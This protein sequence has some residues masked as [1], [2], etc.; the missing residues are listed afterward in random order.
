MQ[1]WKEAWFKEVVRQ[2][3]I[4]L[5]VAML[6]VLGYDRTVAKPRLDG[7]VQQAIHDG[8]QR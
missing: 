3:V 1:F 2:V 4:A 7:A 8:L 6:S 5:L